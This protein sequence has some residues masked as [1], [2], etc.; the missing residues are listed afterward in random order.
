MFWDDRGLESQKVW[1][2]IW[3]EIVEKRLRTCPERSNTIGTTLPKNNSMF[4]VHDKLCLCI[5]GEV[6]VSA[7][8]GYTGY[9][10]YTG[11]T[12]LTRKQGKSAMKKPAQ[13]SMTSH[14]RKRDT[15]VA[16]A[17]RRSH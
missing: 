14:P 4:Q 11:V 15:Y 9:T 2:Q 8:K 10:H 6:S 3:L 5:A 7:W 16:Q 17:Q 12:R 1:R 13:L